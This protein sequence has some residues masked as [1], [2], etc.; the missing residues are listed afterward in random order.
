MAT[1]DLH[2]MNHD[3]ASELVED[4]LLMASVKGDF[5]YKV[6]TGQSKAMRMKIIGVCERWGFGYNI[7]ANNQGEI[8]IQFNKL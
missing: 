3:D 6:I 4:T 8:N 1:I 5:D 2:G 7:P